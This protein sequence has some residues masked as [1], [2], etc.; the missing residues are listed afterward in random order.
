MKIIKI[1]KEPGFYFKVEGEKITLINNR[2]KK[3]EMT[4]DFLLE[5]PEVAIALVN[6]KYEM[7]VSKLEAEGLTRSDAQSVVDVEIRKE[8]FS[9]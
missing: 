5:Y 7:R 8:K 4:I 1:E 9:K 6:E 2:D 3:I